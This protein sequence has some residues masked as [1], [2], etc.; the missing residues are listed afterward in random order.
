[1]CS[2][3][4]CSFQ[5]VCKGWKN[6]TDSDCGVYSPIRHKPHS[7]LTCCCVVT[8]GSGKQK[9]TY[10]NDLESDEFNCVNI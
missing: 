6:V 10:I 5:F 1:M 9:Y 8:E 2:E 4:S 7:S 3:A